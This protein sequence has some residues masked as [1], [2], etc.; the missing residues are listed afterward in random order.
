MVS[1]VLIAAVA[2]AGGPCEYV[3]ECRTSCDAGDAEACFR[4]GA[5]YAIGDRV[6]KDPHIAARLYRQ[7][8]EAGVLAAC[9]ALAEAER[10]G[11]G[12]KQDPSAAFDKHLTNC[13][14][15]WAASCRAVGDLFE[16][17]NV[18]VMDASGSFLWYDR[19]CTAG[20]GPG[21]FYVGLAYEFGDG[22][23]EDPDAALGFYR[24]ACDH[25]EPRACTR[26]A[27]LLTGPESATML[28]FGCDRGDPHACFERATAKTV[29]P[30]DAAGWLDTACMGKVFDAC[31]ALGDV[32]TE[33]G[34]G[35]AALDAYTRGCDLGDKK[36]CRH[37]EAIEKKRT[38]K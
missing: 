20:D 21:C 14:A 25:E 13:E 24:T 1:A 15:G 36:A 38:P 11:E 2:W 8:C 6:P 31:R 29:A 28:G 9:Y 35:R 7:A 32:E 3:F 23:I 19:A 22:V 37:A 30:T 10:T 17:G 33:L 27:H 5:H 12:L 18:V 4:L 26:A 16:L 34:H